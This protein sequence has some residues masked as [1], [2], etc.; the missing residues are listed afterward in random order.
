[1]LRA[2]GRATHGRPATC[3]E[4]RLGH[5]LG[6][7]CDADRACRS[8]STVA[9]GRR[10]ASV[11]RGQLPA[12]SP[13]ACSQATACCSTRPPSNSGSGTG[14]THFVVARLGRGD[15]VSARRAVRRARHEAA[16]HAAAARRAVGRVAGEPAPRRDARRRGSGRDAG[17]LLRAA[18]PGPA[19]GRRDQAGRPEL[20]RRL[21]HDRS[22]RRWRLPLSDVVSASVDAGLIDATITCGQAFGGELRGGQPA[23][24]AARRTARGRVRTS[25]SSRSAPASSGPP[26]RSV[27]VEWR[28]AR[29]STRSPR[30]GGTPIADL[31]LSFA[32]SRDRHRVVSH[33]TLSAL[34]RVA[35]APALVAVPDL[36]ADAGRAGRGGSRERGR[37]AA[38][39]EVASDS[40]ARPRRTCVAWT[41]PRWAAVRRMTPRSSLRR[42]LRESLP[43]TSA[44]AGRPPETARLET[45]AKRP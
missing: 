43:P 26:R 24:G 16:L 2:R 27:T 28:R 11:E 19:R 5:R 45:E 23:L 4:A 20:P 14:G 44:C 25:R 1:M 18:Q 21:L 6:R 39:H 42:S 15:G 31:R 29:R 17:G 33:H 37:V 7:R 10:Q 9:T 36:P 40:A 30:C 38:S 3:D 35:L 41:S 32:D 12:R 13:G 8:S 22:A 34:T